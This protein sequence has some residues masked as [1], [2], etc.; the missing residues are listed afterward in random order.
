MTVGPL[1]CG[2]GQRSS[3]ADKLWGLSFTVSK[4]RDEAGD[5]MK[6]LG[7]QTCLA[8]QADPGHVIQLSK[9]ESLPQEVVNNMCTHWAQ[10][11]ARRRF[12]ASI[13]NPINDR[14]LDPRGHAASH[15]LK[16]SWSLIECSG[17]FCLPQRVP[18][19]DPSCAD[20]CFV[21]GEARLTLCI[22]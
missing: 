10:N 3:T 13:S 7:V 1:F 21:H 8:A 9:S 4:S 17:W 14:G 5:T 20:T 2:A 11:L 6:R 18:A 15:L 22:F 16:A 19:A 12:S